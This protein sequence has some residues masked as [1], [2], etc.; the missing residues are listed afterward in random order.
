MDCLLYTSIGAT[1]GSFAGGLMGLSPS[2]GAAIGLV[3]VFCG[4][5]NSPMTAFVIGIELFGANGALFLSL[6]QI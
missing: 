6:L 1:F 5:I 2:F 4:A 3:S